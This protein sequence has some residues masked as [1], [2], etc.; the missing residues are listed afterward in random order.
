MD[1]MLAELERRQEAILARLGQLK[2]EVE[3]LA[4]VM[5]P[6]VTTSSQTTAAGQQDSLVNTAFTLPTTVINECIFWK[7]DRGLFSPR[8]GGSRILHKKGVLT[9]PGG[10]D[11]WGAT[12]GRTK[13]LKTV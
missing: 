9:L 8:G 12:C 5:L 10:V 7:Y 6:S 2:A 11:G 4:G 1:G 3:K 13:F